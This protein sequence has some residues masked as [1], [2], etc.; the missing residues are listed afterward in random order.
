MMVVSCFGQ[1]LSVEGS[2][3]AP[4][5]L[6]RKKPPLAAKQSWMHNSQS[7]S[8][9]NIAEKWLWWFASSFHA[10]QQPPR[11]RNN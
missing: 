3:F 8:A 7:T 2:C 11:T 5:V 9:I 10:S 4:Y 1:V 6:I